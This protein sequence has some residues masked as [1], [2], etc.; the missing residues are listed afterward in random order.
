MPNEE[1][2]N[3]AY[4]LDLDSIVPEPKRILIKGNIVEAYPPS[5]EDFIILSRLQSRLLKSSS[6]EESMVVFDDL[7]KVILTCLPSLE[8]ELKLEITQVI[9]LTKFLLEMVNPSESAALK[10]LGI[11]QNS[12]EKKN[13]EPG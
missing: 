3:K 13:L 1:Q 4:D 2:I 8:N 7:R 5:L 9:V 12:S 11:T 10:A 6:E